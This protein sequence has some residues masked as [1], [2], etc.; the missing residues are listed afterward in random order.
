MS[1]RVRLVERLATRIGS[2]RVSKQPGPQSVIPSGK[3]VRAVDRIDDEDLLPVALEEAVAELC[4]VRKF[5]RAT[6]LSAR[7][8]RP[9]AG[10]TLLGEREMLYKKRNNY[11]RIEFVY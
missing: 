10:L 2:L 4:S 1:V 7:R 9:R 5:L 11:A 8:G 3:L 6:R